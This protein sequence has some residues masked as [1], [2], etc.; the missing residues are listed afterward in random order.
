MTTD[1]TQ[2]RNDN[3][4]ETTEEDGQLANPGPVPVEAEDA[5]D[6]GE[7]RP[8]DLTAEAGPDQNENPER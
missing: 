4:D 3:T 2:A 6:T 8:G 5:S 1:P 7:G